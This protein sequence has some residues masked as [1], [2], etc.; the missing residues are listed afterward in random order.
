[1]SYDLYFNA[2]NSDSKIGVN[3]FAAYFR[4]RQNFEVSDQQAVYQNKITGVYF[5]FDLADAKSEEQPNLVPVSFNLNYYRPHIFGLEAEIEVDSFVK[6]FD[7][8]VSDPQMDGMGEGE[9]STEKFL[10]GWNK[11]NE[12]GYRAILQQNPGTNPS[13]LST[14]QIEN[15]WRWNLMQPR[16]QQQ[17]GESVFVPRFMFLL[18]EG[19]V[20]TTIVWPDGIPSAV[21]V[22]EVVIIPRKAVLPKKFFR[23]TED[24]VVASWNEVA[25][26]I[27][28]FPL[29][30][31]PLPYHLMKYAEIP[32]KVLAQLRSLAPTNEK[33]TGISVDKILNAEIVAKSKIK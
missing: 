5:V 27:E 19:K 1:M 32:A 31:G 16:L 6:N 8:P 17:L 2:R 3:D 10:S 30:Q 11:G 21:P 14:A 9:Y 24:Q 13:T 33:P 22:A 15:C 29:E 23:S 4:Q 28:Q 18:R 12:F 7:L 20:L 25:P 26:I